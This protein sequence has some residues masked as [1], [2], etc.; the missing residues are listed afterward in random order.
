MAESAYY[1]AVPRAGAC[2]DNYKYEGPYAEA[3]RVAIELL[4]EA[5]A[6]PRRDDLFAALAASRLYGQAELER[7]LGTWDRLGG[8]ERLWACAPYL[9][10]QL[11][12]SQ[13]EGALRGLCRWEGLPDAAKA[14]PGEAALG[15]ADIRMATYRRG[16]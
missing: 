12:L 6:I 2:W 15:Y 14:P 11:D 8:E 5:G 4:T 3:R 1:I 9:D 16:G 10:A 7:L 13:N